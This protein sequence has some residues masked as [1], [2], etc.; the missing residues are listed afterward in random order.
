V[1]DAEE[2]RV[3]AARMWDDAAAGWGEHAASMQ[4][5]AMPVSVWM[6]EAIQPQP[7]QTL[8][9]LAAGA[10]ETGFLAVEL[11]QPGGRLLST[12]GSEEMLEVGRRRAEAVGVSD[13][14]EFRLMQA[15][16]IDLSTATVDAVLCR[17]GYM[18]LADP[19]T[20]LRETRRILHPDG[21]LA[22]AAWA[23]VEHNPWNGALTDALLARGLVPADDDGPGPGV[24][25]MYAFAQDGHIDELLGSV[26]FQD[27]EVEALDFAFQAP[28][29]DAWWAYMNDISPNLRAIVPHLSPADHYALRDA[30][31]AA[32]A[33]YVEDDG[34]VV[35]PA[36]TWVAAATA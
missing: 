23:P 34:R 25:G 6:V 12:D 24:P 5:A 2:Y 17:W 33:P 9:E 18:L 22:L 14:V 4:A 7:G 20:A 13:L 16:W 36:R 28:D 30:V 26:G 10:G 21:R 11:A 1:F 35:V 29:L 32:Y 3:H 8:V 31:D 19:E 15:E 27:I